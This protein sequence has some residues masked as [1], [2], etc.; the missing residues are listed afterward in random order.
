MKIQIENQVIPIDAIVRISKNEWD[1]GN[2]IELYSFTIHLLGNS[3]LTFFVDQIAIIN[4]YKVKEGS[5]EE[6]GL[7]YRDSDKWT[8]EERKDY[9]SKYALMVDFLVK[10]RRAR[11]K[12]V[13]DELIAKWKPEERF[14]NLSQP[15]DNLNI[16][17]N[18]LFND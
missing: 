8:P 9:D 14:E 15:N 3:K 18:S 2:G 12:E 11:L 10:K 13:Y 5:A 17:F 1:N 6:I 4:D 7:I 16:S